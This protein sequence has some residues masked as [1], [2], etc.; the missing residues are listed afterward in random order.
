MMYEPYE[1]KPRREKR[2][3]RQRRKR[4]LLVPLLKL[5]LLLISLAVV[6][7]LA[8]YLLPA[9][10]FAIEPEADLGLA[11]DLPAAPVNILLLGV[12][13]E[14]EGLRRSDTIMV[15]SI[16]RSG[17]RLVSILRDAM[18]EIPGHGR[19]RVNTAYTYGG[20]ELAVRTINENFG[21]N[22]MHY[23]VADYVTLVR[24]V[25][26][27]GGVD[28]DISAEEAE[29]INV[30]VRSMG[31]T[32]KP[33]GYT[34]SP[35]TV[36]GEG[37][38]LNGLQALGYAR[39]RKL[40]S[41]FKRAGRQRVVLAAILSRLKANLWNPVLLT[42]VGQAAFG[43]LETDLQPPLLISLGLKA[44]LAGGIETMRVPVE[45]S[46]EDNGS[47]LTVTDF[48]KNRLALR[49]FLYQ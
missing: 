43:S 45:E 42:R 25:D 20:A 5:A 8:L 10:L 16:G 27:I 34:Y 46:Y 4:S 17:V 26:A 47:T 6:A 28:A 15:A 13:A 31:G 30:N 33:L 2:R 18:V 29:Q 19:G 39:I 32:F 41:D 48:Q 36:S 35:L 49:A 21:L 24:L 9:G 11:T 12:D 22:I 44:A 7:G 37:T 23:C 3:D 38:H 14:N 40:D 1:R